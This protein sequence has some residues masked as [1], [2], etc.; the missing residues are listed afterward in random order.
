MPC[1]GSRNRRRHLLEGD[2]ARP[3]EGIGRTPLFPA[4]RI[5]ATF[6]PR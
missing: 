4:A 3:D 5:G 2:Q 6:M 1:H